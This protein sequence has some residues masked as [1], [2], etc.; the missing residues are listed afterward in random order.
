ME[1]VDV[2]YLV[3]HHQVE[4]HFLLSNS[5]SSSLVEQEATNEHGFN[6]GSALKTAALA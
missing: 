6:W 1:A 3:G 5:L 4:V 2:A